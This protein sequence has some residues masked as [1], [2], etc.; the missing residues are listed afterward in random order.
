MVYM[1]SNAAPHRI[2]PQFELKFC[3]NNWSNP[4]SEFINSGSISAHWG[5]WVE[6]YA[7]EF[8]KES[9]NGLVDKPLLHDREPQHYLPTVCRQNV[10][11]TIRPGAIDGMCAR[12]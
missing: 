3:H 11:A 12:L 4:T 8:N 9:H 6:R 7:R 1:F 10:S 2:V 5:R